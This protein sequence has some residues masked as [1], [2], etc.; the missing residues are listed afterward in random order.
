A[1]FEIQTTSSRKE[2]ALEF[3]RKWKQKMSVSK[4]PPPLGLHLVM[5]ENF[6][7]K[8][9][10]FLENI[11]TRRVAPFEIIAKLPE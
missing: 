2:F 3:F 8:L 6:F 7:E 11:K 4:S 10:N 1:G 9:T 5:G